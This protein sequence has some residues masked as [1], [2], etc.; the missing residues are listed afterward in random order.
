MAQQA[1]VLISSQTLASATA[2]VTFSSITSGFR[3]LRLVVAGQ[4]TAA[5]N[6]FVTLNGDSTASNYAWIWMLSNGSTTSSTT[7]TDLV[8]GDVQP[9][10][11][12]NIYD[13]LD[14]SAT[15]KHKSALARVSFAGYEATVVSKRWANT[16]AIT[17]IA[18]TANGT[19]WASGTTFYLYGVLG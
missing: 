14:Y 8:F 1:H 6:V 17:S 7:G 18:L 2:T 13:F 3:D 9:G 10:P 15:D 11:G 4:S 16:A 12:T 19:T 5:A